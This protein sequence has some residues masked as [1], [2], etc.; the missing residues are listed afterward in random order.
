MAAN[1]P[2]TI[3][4][5]QIEF[6]AELILS[7][8]NQQTVERMVQTIDDSSDDNHIPTAKAVNQKITGIQKFVSVVVESGD[9]EDAE[10][11]P[12]ENTMYMVRTSDEAEEFVPYI[13]I[14]GTGF[15]TMPGT[16]G[17]TGTT[18]GAMTDAD[19][20]SAITAAA[21][22]VVVIPQPEPEPDPEPDPDP[23]D[24]SDDDPDEGG[25]SE[26]GTAGGTDTSGD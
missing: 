12:D 4:R 26:G 17:S 9:P 10:I 2:V 21:N 3:T 14:E 6:M 7:A 13:W 25:T 11:E 8:A 23:E 19:I 22:S 24:P 5:S 16:E 1:D 20:V 18:I 15:I